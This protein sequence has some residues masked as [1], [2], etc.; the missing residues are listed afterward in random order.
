MKRK[1]AL[2]FACFAAA[3]ILAA[4][5][6]GGIFLHFD[7]IEAELLETSVEPASWSQ[8]SEEALDA[9]ADF[10]LQF[11]ESC[12]TKEYVNSCVSPLS[13][14]LA[15]G[16]TA[17]GADGDTLSQ[18]ETLLGGGEGTLPMVNE[19][20]RALM[21][22]LPMDESGGTIH[23][24]NSIWFDQNVPYEEFLKINQAYYDA[25]IYRADFSDKEQLARDV[26][27]WASNQTDG[28]IE[29]FLEPD[30][31]S[32]LA[33]L[34][35]LNATLF[36]VKWEEKIEKD[37]VYDDTFRSYD[38]QEREVPFLH[39][40]GDYLEEPGLY[41]GFRKRYEGSCVFVGLLPSGG[42]TPEELAA[43]LTPAQLRNLA[44]T[45]QG[46]ARG[47]FPKFRIEQEISLDPGL[48]EMG[49]VKFFFKDGANFSR[50]FPSTAN[51]YGV[52]AADQAVF[53]DVNEN[54]T[55]AAAVTRIE[56][57][58]SAAVSAETSVLVE[59]DRPFLYL[60]LDT[61]TGLPLF[62]G[63]VNQLS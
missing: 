51:R 37:Q 12:R 54:G 8:P 30:E 59:L 48:R 9:A 45:R 47:V 14:Y 32:D 2:K 1:K 60:I 33:Q 46:K 34:M 7:G 11:F 16:L 3:V 61:N 4:G 56:M 31:I 36:D 42:R 41:T 23:L 43:Q 24:A 6:L 10:S 28:L 15:L 26:S 44:G 27:R 58:G 49:L 50:M 40:D 53:I 52:G 57:I 22:L 19:T 62:M 55:K 21:E 25:Q 17:N 63:A 13:A 18:M 5:A 38:G 35:L 29:E 39:S 20:C